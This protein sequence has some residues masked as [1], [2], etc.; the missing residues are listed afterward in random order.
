MIETAWTI[1]VTNKWQLNLK[2][3][4]RIISKHSKYQEERQFFSK[5]FA[6]LWLTKVL[7]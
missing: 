5:A 3:K 7:L 4:N 6:M 2:V 1:K